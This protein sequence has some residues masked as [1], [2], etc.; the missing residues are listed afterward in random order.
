M[1][2][3][4]ITV[5]VT[6]L[7]AASLTGCGLRAGDQS[8]QTEQ[9]L[10][11]A[12]TP[13]GMA[14]AALGFA[15]QDVAADDPVAS[16]DPEPDAGHPRWRA[17]RE[18]RAARVLLRS[19]MLHG[20]IVVRTVDGTRTVLVQRG[21]VTAISSTGLTVASTDGFTQTWTF[22]DPMRVIEARATITPRELEVGAPVGVAGARLD[23]EPTARLVVI[24]SRPG[25]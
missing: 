5:L 6:A 21:E 8:G 14:L 25:R 17:W 24:P 2:R 13:E 12:L 3:T 16:A 22:G 23:G 7:A 10:T 4:V 18:R 9:E 20:E 11:A 15:E 19:H 1:G